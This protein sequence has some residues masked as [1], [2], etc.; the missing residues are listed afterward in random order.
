MC[1]PSTKFKVEAKQ[2][3][4]MSKK[5]FYFILLPNTTT[6]VWLTLAVDTDKSCSHI[7]TKTVKEVRPS[8]KTNVVPKAIQ[9]CCGQWTQPSGATKLTLTFSNEFTHKQCWVLTARLLHPS[10]P[11][12]LDLVNFVASG[13][14]KHQQTPQPTRRAHYRARIN[15]NYHLIYSFGG[16]NVPTNIP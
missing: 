16:N 9:L 7:C 14:W 12:S 11:E 13:S 4:Q 3:W 2:P 8:G 1:L 10:E 6:A 15:V 5:L